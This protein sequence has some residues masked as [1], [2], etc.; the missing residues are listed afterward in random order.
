M[1]SN[2][3]TPQPAGDAAAPSHPPLA[4]L[5]A[6]MSLQQMPIYLQSMQLAANPAVPLPAAAAGSGGNLPIRLAGNIP[7]APA[8]GLL[9]LPFGSQLAQ[10]PLFDAS[11]YLQMMQ[12]YSGAEQ[13]QAVPH[14]E[15]AG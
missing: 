3:A 8:A 7:S 11:Q 5:G 10:Q 1:A 2:S 4:A 15:F 14:A 9:A 13:V 6:Q 12:R